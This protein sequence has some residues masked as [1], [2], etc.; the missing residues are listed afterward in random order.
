MQRLFVAL[1][2]VIPFAAQ[3]QTTQC[4]PNNPSM[5]EAGTT[6]YDNRPP[7]VPPDS[8]GGGGATMPI[9]GP[10]GP[11]GVLSGACHR[12]K[13]ARDREASEVSALI[14]RGDCQGAINRALK[15]NDFDMAKKAKDL[16]MSH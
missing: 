11:F 5:P 12:Q 2:S 6:C 7:P 1:L 13:V 15:E 8:S 4:Y 9:T 14:Q 3:A 10:C 16:C